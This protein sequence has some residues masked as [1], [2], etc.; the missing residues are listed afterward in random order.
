MKKSILYFSL[1]LFGLLM[2]A[3]RSHKI[4]PDDELALIF[5]DAFLANSYLERGNP[6]RDSLLLYEPIFAH[7]GYTTED[8]RYT[9]GNFS[10]RKSARLGD[11]V[12]QAISLL[13][14]EGER[15]DKIVADLDTVNNVARRKTERLYHRDT[16]IKAHR[17]KD[18]VRLRIVLD[19]IPA[20]DYR[21]ESRYL[22]DSLDENFGHRMQ[23]WFER[24]NESRMALQSISLKRGSEQHLSRT[25]TADSSVRRL[26]IDFWPSVRNVKR[27]RPHITLQELTITRILPAEEAID[28]LYAREVRV[29]IFADDLLQILQTDSLPL[30]AD[31]TR[32][33]AQPAH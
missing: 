10:K 30:A 22:I 14:K 27:K 15:L 32:V 17:L 21:I 25:I 12:E 6:K 1:L 19:S 16:L 33:A 13:E 28:S 2:G 23:C 18:T 20:G 3:C 24:S 9:I 11:V 29:R 31:T 5:H 26:V 7:Y 8:V 4:I